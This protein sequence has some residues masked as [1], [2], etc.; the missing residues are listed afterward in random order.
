MGEIRKC[1][2]RQ[3]V[4]ACLYAIQRDYIVYE[5]VAQPLP[6][7]EMHPRSI[8]GRGRGGAVTEALLYFHRHSR[9]FGYCRFVSD[10][11][12]IQKC[13]NE[14][15]IRSSAADQ[16]GSARCMLKFRCISAVKPRSVKKRFVK[17][18][19]VKQASL[20]WVASICD[21]SAMCG[22]TLVSLS[23]KMA[24]LQTTAS[25]GD[26]RARQP[27]SLDDCFSQAPATAC[28]WGWQSPP[29]VADYAPLPL[30]AFPA[31]GA[32]SP[33]FPLQES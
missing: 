16:V 5:G 32:S 31:N 11:A 4:G 18:R 22:I 20:P 12:V 19:S 27:V 29:A 7:D 13:L 9:L 21:L 17:Q 28:V 30:P 6:G 26:E 15:P 2:Q 25:C 33:G 24:G 23:G 3:C 1:Q 14:K 8:T 10:Q